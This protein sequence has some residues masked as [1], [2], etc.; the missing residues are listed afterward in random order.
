M[1]LAYILLKVFNGISQ[2][3]LKDNLLKDNEF[4]VINGR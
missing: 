3:E 1:L 2:K 4:I